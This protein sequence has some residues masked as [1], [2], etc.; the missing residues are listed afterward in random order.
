L[1]WQDGSAAQQTLPVTYNGRPYLVVT[2]ELGSGGTVG[3]KP[4]AC[5]QGLPP[6][7]FTRIIDISDETRPMTIAKLMLEVHDPANCPFT[8]NDPAANSYSAHYCN[9]DRVQDPRLI[10]CTYW[11]SGL[12]VFNIENPYRPTEIAYYKPP[13]R[14]LAYLPGSALWGPTTDRTVDHSVT[15]VRWRHHGDETHLWFVSKDNGFQIVRFTNGVLNGIIGPRD[16]FDG[17]D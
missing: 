7:G 5:A 1:I 9:V 14:R 11:S 12:R 17:D 16:R 15:Q 2:D 10:A 4:L 8:L 3:G 13:A 6:F